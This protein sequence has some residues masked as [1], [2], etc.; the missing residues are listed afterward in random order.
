MKQYFDLQMFAETGAQEAAD[1]MQTVEGAP[2]AQVPDD[3]A[4]SGENTDN[5]A[6]VQDAAEQETTSESPSIARAFSA[7]SDDEKISLFSDLVKNDPALKKHQKSEFKTALNGRTA[8]IRQEAEQRAHRYDSLINQLS[9]VYGTDDVSKLESM[10]LSDE[11]LLQGEAYR[12]G[13]SIEQAKAQRQIDL[14]ARQL[15]EV[16]AQS[17]EQQRISSQI[18]EWRSQAEDLKSE[19]P[20]FNFDAEFSDEDT[21]KEFW[22]MLSSGVSMETAYKIIHQDEI[23]AQRVSAAAKAAKKQAVDTIK[24]RGTRPAESGNS[25]QAPSNEK[26]D[27]DN[28]TDEQIRD[29]VKRVQHGEK[30]TF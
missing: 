20:D 6:E 24:A 11:H 5:L 23:I 13:I 10:I 4:Q 17:D 19:Y 21:G 12:K 30:I 8:K 9:I 1:S 26:I 29:I 27:V 16:R 3:A 15:D 22:R 2:S 18:S 14:Q 7:L 28:L 25:S